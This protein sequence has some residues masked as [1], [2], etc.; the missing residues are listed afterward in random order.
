[1]QPFLTKGAIVKL[2]KRIRVQSPKTI[3]FLIMPRCKTFITEFLEGSNIHSN[4]M[5]IDFDSKTENVLLNQDFEYNKLLNVVSN[6]KNELLLP[7]QYK[8]LLNLKQNF[9]EKSIVVISSNINLSVYTSL[10]MPTEINVFI[11]SPKYYTILLNNISDDETKKMFFNDYNSII[12]S[13]H[14]YDVY[15]SLEDI[16][17][18]VKEL[19]M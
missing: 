1:V 17:E 10:R 15:T 2:L 18:K 3:T 5:V 16:R 19:F 6:N 11:P 14:K 12:L 8:S 9:R 4:L 7:I 13:K